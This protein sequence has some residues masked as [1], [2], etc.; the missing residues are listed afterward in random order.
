M[1]YTAWSVVFGEQPTAA[2]WNQLGANDAGFRDGTNIDD[3]AIVARHF[4]DGAI[5]FSKLDDVW[6]EEL[7][8]AEIAAP[9]TSISVSF[10]ARKNLRVIF[11]P[12][13]FQSSSSVTMR[14]NNISSAQYSWSRNSFSTSPVSSDTQGTSDNSISLVSNTLAPGFYEMD[15][16]NAATAEKMGI[17]FQMRSTTGA[18]SSIVRDQTAFKWVNVA[19]ITRIDIILTG[20]MDIG[21]EIIVLGHD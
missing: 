4:A 17:G 11:R 10:A 9:A 1:A 5:P 19:Q 15:I 6:Y 20:N 13:G 16:R 3:G 21:S 7:G 12:T 14:F 2:K 8:R 18:A